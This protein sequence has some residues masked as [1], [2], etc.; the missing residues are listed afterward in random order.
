MVI[1]LDFPARPTLAKQQIPRTEGTVVI[2]EIPA[3]T[4]VTSAGL[5]SHAIEQL[6]A[7]FC[8][9]VHQHEIITAKPDNP[10]LREVV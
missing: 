4:P 6:A 5:E 9:T 3:I 10:A 8:R 2:P 7:P 1:S